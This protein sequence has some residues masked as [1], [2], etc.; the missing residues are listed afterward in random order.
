MYYSPTTKCRL[1]CMGRTQDNKLY[2]FTCKVHEHKV[3]FLAEDVRQVVLGNVTWDRELDKV[4]VLN[5]RFSGYVK[6][7]AR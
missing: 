3:Y 6:G 1:K 7:Y 4:Y 5:G 2:R